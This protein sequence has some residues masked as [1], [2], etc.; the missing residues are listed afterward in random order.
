MNISIDKRGDRVVVSVEGRI[1][2]V[3]APEL[4]KRLLE[5]ISQGDTRLIVDFARVDYICSAGLKSLMVAARNASAGGG[6]LS[7]SAVSGVVEKVFQ[8]S[9]FATI[10]PLYDSVEDAVERS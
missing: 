2:T 5:R 9:G 3:S 1:D 7:C 10:L 6:Q 4:E 8:V